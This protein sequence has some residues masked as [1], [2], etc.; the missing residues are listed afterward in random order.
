MSCATP[1]GLRWEE[2]AVDCAA[3]NRSPLALFGAARACTGGVCGLEECCVAEGC[4]DAPGW[5]AGYGGWECATIAQNGYCASTE[6][7]YCGA[8]G[9]LCPGQ[10]CC[11]CGGGSVARK[12]PDGAARPVDC[13]GVPGAPRA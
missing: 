5:V 1:R 11:A 13:N 9:G 2:D 3:A 12:A 10:A 8:D 7:S 4:R 6:S